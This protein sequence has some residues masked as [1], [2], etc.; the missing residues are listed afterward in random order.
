M[1][2]STKAQYAQMNALRLYGL[3]LHLLGNRVKLFRIVRVQ[4]FSYLSSN[5]PIPFR[6]SFAGMDMRPDN[7]HPDLI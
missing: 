6:Y 2:I 5:P 7:N 1:L 3:K 4:V